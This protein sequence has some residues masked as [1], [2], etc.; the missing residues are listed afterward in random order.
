MPYI[1]VKT[2]PNRGKLF[3][4]KDAT[5]GIGRDES[6]VIQILDQGVSRNHAEIFRIGEMC[7]VRDL[8][9]TNGTFVNDVRVTEESL[10]AGDELMIGTTILVFEDR[11]PA[12]ASGDAAAVVFEDTGKIETTTLEMK[13]DEPRPGSGRKVIGKEVQSRNI[14]LISQVGRIIRGERDLDSM[15][16][17]V[18]ELIAGAVRAN[19]GYVITLERQTGRPVPRASVETEEGGERKVSRMILNRVRET[20]MP[21]LT[22]DATLD[23]RFALSESI[24]LKKIKSVICVPIMIEERVEGFLYLHSSKVDHLLTLED[25]DL[26]AA[27]AFQI[28][29]AMGSWEAR[30]KLRLGLMGTI[31]ALVTAMEI[32]DPGTQGHAQ[33]VADTS[34]TVAAQMGLPAEEI[35]RVRLAA[36]LHDVG[37]VAVHQSVAGLSPQQVR[38][39][40]VLAGEKVLAGIEG[41]EEVLPG[42]RFHHER[43]DGSGFPYRVKNAEIPVMA[44]IVLVMNAFDNECRQGGGAGPS[45]PVKEV[46]KSMAARAGKEF[47]ADVVRALLLCHRNGTLYGAA[48]EP[49]G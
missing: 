2:G 12:A 17:K 6:Q 41:F 34:A 22:S 40:H 36:L 35:H 27:V 42:V 48:A 43:A 30:E 14:T 1:R 5:L 49:K 18:V 25:L 37:K 19:H 38:E 10:K 44:R 45:L 13:V 26:A 39:Q 20:A 31:R 15:F 7:F 24:I 16:E 11:L 8:N 3:E 21:L 32:L 28:S 9:S 47:D 29:L 46:L 23:D 4:I 33:R